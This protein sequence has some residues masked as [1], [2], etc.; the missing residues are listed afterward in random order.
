MGNYSLKTR[1][2][3]ST[4]FSLIF[5]VLLVFYL[6][7]IE[8]FK[9]SREQKSI[10]NLLETPITQDFVDNIIGLRFKNRIGQFT[11]KKEKDD[12]ILQKPRVVPAKKQTINKIIQA[13]KTIKVHTIHQYEPINFESFSLDKPVIEIELLNKLEEKMDIKVGLINPINST[14]YITV[15]GKDRI[16]QTNLFEGQLES[17]ELSDFIDAN[18]FSMSIDEI[19]SFNLYHGKNKEAF[20]SLTQTDH[21]W[22]AKKYNTITNQNV[23][24]KINS[25]LSIKTHI[26]IDEVNE[27]LSTIIENYFNNPLYQIKIELNTGEVIEYK[28]SY[29][30][31]AIKELKIEKQEFFLITATNRPYPYLISKSFFEEFRIRY[32]DLK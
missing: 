10:T 31:K 22:K 11:I 19:K 7:S 6:L 4:W 15:S 1:N 23:I 17:L 25:I 24:N 13:L 28:V 20:N 8:I 3:I 12:W 29:L 2:L 16:F 9:G 14:S 21:V 26:I 18:I 30:T 27:E 32:Q 5:F